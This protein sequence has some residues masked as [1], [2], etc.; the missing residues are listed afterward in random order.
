MMIN[1]LKQLAKRAWN[2]VSKWR[3][4]HRIKKYLSAGMQPWTPGYQDYKEKMIR[5]E[6]ADS[7]TV[8]AIARGKVPDGYGLHL[9]ERIVEYPWIFGHLPKRSGRLLDAGSTFNFN[10][11]LE[12]KILENKELTIIT[13]SPEETNYHQR[14]I[15][16]VYSDLRSTPIRDSFFDIIVSQS[17]IEHIDMDNSIYGYDLRHNTV[18]TAKSYEFLKAIQEYL[19]ILKSNGLLLL[20]FPFGAFENHGFFQ[21]FDAEMLIRITK[22]L[23]SKGSCRLN[24]FRYTATGWVACEKEDCAEVH[25]YNPHTGRG[26]GDDGAAHCR[27]ICC[28]YFIK[29]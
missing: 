9:D 29:K 1:S 15:S 3:T 14:R 17:T 5:I 22:V 2:I 12:Q 11:I 6:L 28:I 18:E 23:K 25:S 20:T 24:F 8:T 27:S 7:A 13:F 21:Q 10:F 26:K 19:R 4:A 16:Y